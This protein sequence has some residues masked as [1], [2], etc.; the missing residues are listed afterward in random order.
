MKKLAFLAGAT[1]FAASAIAA[2][3]ARPANMAMGTNKWRINVGVGFPASD[4][5]D[6]GVDTQIMLGVDMELG[7]MN[8]GSPATSYVG[9]GYMFG[10]GDSDLDTRSWGFHYGVMFPLSNSGQTSALGGEIQLGYYNT[11]LKQGSAK[12]DKWALG[13]QAALT[14]TPQG[15]TWSL[16]A[17][18]YFMPEVESINNNGWFIGA[19]FRTK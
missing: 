11:E 13:G 19:S 9:L 5:K 18:Y 17:G 16:K 8:Y 12:A 15:Q 4:H 2:E 3:S 1:V 10:S 7:S 14:W 6:L